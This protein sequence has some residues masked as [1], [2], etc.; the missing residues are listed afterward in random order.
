M[1]FNNS[2]RIKK[3]IS[4]KC[5]PRACGSSEAQQKKLKEGG[6][7][8]KWPEKKRMFSSAL[9]KGKD[10]WPKKEKGKDV[11]NCNH[12][13]VIVISVVLWPRKV[14]ILIPLNQETPLHWHNRTHIPSWQNYTKL[15]KKKHILDCITRFKYAKLPKNL[16]LA[17]VV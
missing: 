7:D 10:F 2:K 3:C 5:Y 16:L 9:K 14:G 4:F 13:T 1:Y 15:L 12:N 11:F 6:G 17:I 8:P